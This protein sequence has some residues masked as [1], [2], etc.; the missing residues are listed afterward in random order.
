MRAIVFVVDWFVLRDILSTTTTA[1]RNRDEV[2]GLLVDG[3]RLLHLLQ[4]AGTSAWTAT[5]RGPRLRRPVRRPGRGYAVR[6]WWL[7][8]RRGR[9]RAA[10]VAA[11]LID[12]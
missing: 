6:W 11:A 12:H 5:R 10:D 1:W 7:L 3:R 8:S 4:Q 9:R 2:R